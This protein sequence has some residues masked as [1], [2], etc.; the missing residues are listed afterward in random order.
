MDQPKFFQSFG[1]G[2]LFMN[3]WL[4]LNMVVDLPFFATSNG[5][6]AIYERLFAAR[7][8]KFVEKQM[9][10]IE[11]IFHFYAQMIF[12]FITQKGSEYWTSLMSRLWGP[13]Y[14]IR[15]FLHIQ[16]MKCLQEIEVENSCKSGAASTI[17]IWFSLPSK[18]V[19][20]DF[21]W[22]LLASHSLRLNE[23]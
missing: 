12:K 10:N 2:L 11:F 8:M 6:I 18:S 14:Y 7:P 21:Q 23:I 4:D 1:S 16:A 20:S 15:W 3:D 22:M 5:I 19:I 9:W 17:Y 13:I